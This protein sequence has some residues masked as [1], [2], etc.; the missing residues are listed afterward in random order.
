M[1][2]LSEI[3]WKCIDCNLYLCQLCSNNI[4]SKIESSKG[5]KIINYQE[6]GTDDAAERQRRV[7]LGNLPALNITVGNVSC[8]VAI[9]AL[10]NK[11]SHKSRDT[12][13]LWSSYEDLLEKIRVQSCSR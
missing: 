5:H 2:V 1:P 7:N 4:H 12:D 10:C 6:A 9:C 11:E 8:T 3:C 13:D